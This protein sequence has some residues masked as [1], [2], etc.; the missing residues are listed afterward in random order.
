[1][2]HLARSLWAAEW[3]SV[4]CGSHPSRLPR[5]SE[6]DS[7]QSARARYVLLAARRSIRIQPER[8]SKARAP[9]TVERP[10]VWQCP[11]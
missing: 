10:A 3:H 8:L 7:P 4:R 11:T 2:C 6:S 1:M 5:W 9:R